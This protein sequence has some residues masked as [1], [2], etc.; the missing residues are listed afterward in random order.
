MANFYVRTGNAGTDPDV[1]ID[2]LGIVIPTGATWT[3]LSEGDS[4]DPSIAGVGQFTSSELRDSDDLHILVTGGTLEF[5]LDGAAQATTTYVADVHLMEDFEDDH[6]DLRSGRLT[7]PSDT[8][9]PGTIASPQPGD[10]FYDS[11]DGYLVFY[12]GV[13]GQWISI[14][15]SGSVLTDHGLLA[16]LLDDDHPQYGL[17]AGNAA[18]NAVTGKYDFNGGELGLPTAAD[19]TTAYPSATAGDIAYDTDDGYLV[20]Y[21]GSAW[22]QLFDQVNTSLDHGDLTGLLDDDHTQ[23]GLLAGNAARNAV[24]GTYDFTD[25]YLV[26]PVKSAAPTTNVVDGELAVVGGI[27]YAYDATRT[28]WLSVDRVTVEASKQNGARNVYLRVGD[29]VASSQTGYRVLR[30]ATITGLSAQTDNVE[31]WT[32]EVRRNGVATP[33]AT[34]AITAANGDQDAA[35]NADLAAGDELQLFANTASGRIRAPVALIELAWRI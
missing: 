4:S 5:S 19:P 33:V 31:S 12:N 18:R 1:S 26:A 8:N 6:F 14:T 3:L 30:D 15:D 21:N 9:P 34:L 17:L 11:D 23:Y 24:T 20:F 10:L 35:V 27:L 32:L 29:G 7:L 2:D 22:I 25:G 28:K 16:G 13:L